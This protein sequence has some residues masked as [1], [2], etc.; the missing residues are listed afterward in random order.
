MNLN[1]KRLFPDHD[2]QYPMGLRPSDAATFFKTTDS[3]GAMLAE[4]KRWL[5]SNPEIYAA[6]DTEGQPA[7]H[8]FARA[9][10]SWL[11]LSQINKELSDLELTLEL[12]GACEPDW[13]ILRPDTAGTFRLACGAVCFPSGWALTEKLGRPLEEIHA[14]VP[15]LNAAL[16]RQIQHFLTAIKPGASWERD[17]WGLSAD[18][19]LNHHPA[20]NWKRLS[21]S[22][23]PESTGLRLETQILH[24]LPLSQA[25]LFSIR[26][27]HHAV[28]D[29]AREPAAA[30]RFLRALESM[31]AVVALYKGVTPIRTRL[32][33]WLRAR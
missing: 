19:E 23:T 33:D 5:A 27:T 15:G 7:L 31:P 21:S 29:I 32:I 20:L 2:F 4:R 22:T 9:L 25:I 18:T 10:Q 26:V 13:L 16:G 3:S 1:W 12:G 28:S 6:V 24:K 30:A 11:Q 17:N 8:E 14:T